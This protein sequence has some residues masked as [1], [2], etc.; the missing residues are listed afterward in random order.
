MVLGVKG[1]WEWG[2]KDAE[3]FSEILRGVECGVPLINGSLIRFSGS[4]NASAKRC[5]AF[6]GAAPTLG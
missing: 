3:N 4:R 2:G 6:L 1:E 5:E